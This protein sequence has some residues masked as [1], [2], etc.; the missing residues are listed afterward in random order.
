[1]D[2]WREDALNSFFRDVRKTMPRDAPSSLSDAAYLDIVAYILKVNAFPG[3]KLPLT[4]MK[5]LPD[6]SRGQPNG[7]SA[8]R[9]GF[10]AG[11]GLWDVS[12]QLNRRFVDS[13][14]R[15]TED[16]SERVTRAIPP[17]TN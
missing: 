13:R 2:S 8:A 4:I 11:I 17:L 1:M 3:G 6:I 15:A 9:A 14:L 7:W 10:L 12:T 16:L 5:T